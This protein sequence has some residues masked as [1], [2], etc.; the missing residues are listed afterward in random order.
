[1]WDLPG[2][3]LEPVFPALAGGF[4]TTVPPGKSC[5]WFFGSGI[6]AEFGWAV[7]L[8]HLVRAVSFTHL[9]SPGGWVGLEV[10]SKLYSHVLHFG[11]SPHGLSPYTGLTSASSHG[12]LWLVVL[13][14]WWLVSKEHFRRGKRRIHRSLKTSLESYTSTSA[15]FCLSKCVIGLV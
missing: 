15:T 9:H 8:L 6:E 13:L 14:T 3:G 11:A 7:F 12:G 10:P 5:S 4:L 1:M 2:P